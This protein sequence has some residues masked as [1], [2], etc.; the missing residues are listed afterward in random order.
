MK[1]LLC[2]AF[3]LL[4][5]CGMPPQ[6]KAMKILNDGLADES[7]IIKVSAVRGLIE[8]GDPRGLTAIFEIL[9]GDDK[10]GI[11]ASLITLSDLGETRYSPVIAS[12]ADHADPLIRTETFRLI[13]ASTEEYIPQIVNGMDDKVAKVRKMAVLAAGRQKAADAVRKGLSDKDPLVRIAAAK[14]LIMMG[15]RSFENYIIKEM[16]SLVIDVWEESMIALAEVNDTTTIATFRDAMAD[17][18]WEIRLAAAEA[19]TIL[20]RKDGFGTIQEA[21]MNDNP[22]VR[23]R[24]VEILKKH[25]PPAAGDMLVSAVNDEYINVS[26]VAIQGLARLK[27]K[28]YQ[29]VFIDLMNAPNPLVRIAAASAYLQNI[30]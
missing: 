17:G 5:A 18:P 25:R 27:N 4:C 19:F 14:M 15:D 6:Q 2:A 13:A 29:T 7:I 8:I 9:R 28:K 16:S 3:L 30:R 20:N 21:L 22:F 1:K 23:A 10:N 12:L 26:V 11:V 24:A